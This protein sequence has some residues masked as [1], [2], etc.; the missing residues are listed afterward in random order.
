MLIVTG[1]GA[2]LCGS[3]SSFIFHPASFRRA[4]A[5]ADVVGKDDETRFGREGVIG[6]RLKL[7]G[8]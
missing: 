8:G 3:S 6:Q 5:R 1:T 2:L 7:P 4:R